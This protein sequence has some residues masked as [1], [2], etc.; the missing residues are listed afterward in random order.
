MVLWWRGDGCFGG[1][2]MVLWWRG[3]GALVA[4]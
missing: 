3:D 1:V 4:W 2:V